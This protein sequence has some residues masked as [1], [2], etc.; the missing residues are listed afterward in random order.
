MPLIRLLGRPSI[1]VEGVTV[2]PP[3]GN[4]SW[5]VLTYVLLAE[6]P[7]SRRHLAE[8]LFGDAD[9]PLGALRWSIAEVRRSLR[10]LAEV[11]GDPLMITL[12]TGVRPVVDVL[13]LERAEVRRT[14]NGEL[15]DGMYFEGSDAFETWLLVERRR[16]G[17]IL[18]SA[19]HEDALRLLAAGEVAQATALASR[20]VQMSP[21]DE[22]F[23]E[24]LV[25][26]LAKSG[27]REA[28]VRQAERFRELLR[29]ELGLDPSPAV[30][31]AADVGPAE[32]SSPPRFGRAAAVAQLEAGRA[33]I[34]AGVVGTGLDRLRRAVVEAAGSG[35]VHLH[36]SA[37][38]AL[39]GALIHAIRGRDEEG[40]GVLHE[41][42]GLAMECGD[43]RLA[44][45]ACREL[46]F[47]DV[48]AGRRSRADVW[49]SRAEA[50]ADGDDAELA[51]IVGV[52]GM[53]LLDRAHHAEALSSFERS[54]E[55]CER[56]ATH[57]QHAWS[58]SLAGR[59]HLEM[60]RIPQARSAIEHALQIT[61]NE[62]WIAFA[63]W[64]EAVGAE[65]DLVDQN[66]ASATARY[67]HAFELA[68]EVGDPCWEGFAAKGMGMTDFA[69]GDLPTATTWLDD[70]YRRSIRWPDT[71][72]WV[73]ASILDAACAVAITR[74]DSRAPDLVEQLSALAA[75]TD[76]RLLVV[77]SHVHRA[78]LGQAGAVDAATMAAATI[79][80]PVLAKLVEND[81]LGR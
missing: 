11:G 46:G 55:H 5:A 33:A 52:R 4:K 10:S 43:Q 72:Q 16:L 12:A 53:N 27:Q 24:L 49:L 61:R 13:D 21:L 26:C 18:E 20:V 36:G 42:L 50:Y 1:E 7:P 70:A 34:A 69:R 23:Q 40:L 71:N 64:P 44:A 80:S 63:P 45:T 30:R 28:A 51:S 59:A 48:Q 65:I 35:D 73:T 60:G 17:A 39:G 22:N 78:R 38:V 66:I 57:R 76:M 77:H 68:C 62:R 56:A 41:G 29:R 54:I 8:L 2:R 14:T 47:V 58:L 67:S 9:D 75:R 81:L 32:L 74:G 31:R 3:R 37:L 79:D 15:L 6:R 19:L 25:R